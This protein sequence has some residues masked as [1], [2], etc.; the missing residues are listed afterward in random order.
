MEYIMYLIY[1]GRLKG[2]QLHLEF[3]IFFQNKLN[4]II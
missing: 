4:S 1:N 3:S 2:A